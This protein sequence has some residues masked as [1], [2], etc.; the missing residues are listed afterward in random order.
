MKLTEIL[1]LLAEKSDPN[2][3]AANQKRGEHHSLKLSDLRGVAKQAKTDHERAKELWATENSDAR[4]LALLTCSPKK[5]SAEELDVMVREAQGAKEQDWLQNYVI[6]KSPHANVLREH[7]LQDEDEDVQAAGWK[8][9]NLQL[10]KSPEDVDSGEVL[11]EIHLRM[12]R[13]SDRLQWA[14]NEV[15]AN[16]GINQPNERARA[17]MIGEDLKV[18]ADYPVSKGCVSPFAPIWIKE[19]VS[20]QEG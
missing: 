11:T 20:R 15:L 6:N 12:D 14:M 8:L 17:I 7:W 13:V 1:Q 5:F 19:M 9:I 10:G 16:I 18:L 3:L 4:L 2:M